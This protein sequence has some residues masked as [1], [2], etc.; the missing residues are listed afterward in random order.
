MLSAKFPD[1]ATCIRQ[2][3]IEGALSKI[4]TGMML[5][6]KILQEGK[7]ALWKEERKGTRGWA[8]NFMPERT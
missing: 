8:E 1:I 3:D 4:I 2:L 6:Q 7:R 5:D